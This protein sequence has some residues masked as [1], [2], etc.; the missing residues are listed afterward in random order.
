MKS[1]IKDNL[2]HDVKK[3]NGVIAVLNTPFTKDNRIDTESIE[4]YVEYAIQNDVSGFLVTAMAAENIYH[5]PTK[6]L[7]KYLLSS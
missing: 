3:L 6:I 7:E 1:F 5:L 4:A 2:P